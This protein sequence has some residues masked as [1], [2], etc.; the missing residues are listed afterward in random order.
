MSAQFD[1]SRF[2]VQVRGWYVQSGTRY[3]LS[4]SAIGQTS[5]S[6]GFDGQDAQTQYELTGTIT[7]GR[8]EIDVHERHISTMA[9]ATSL[10]LLPSQRGSASRF[11]AA[12]NS[13]VRVTGDEYRF[14]NVQ[15]QTDQRTRGT[16]T[17]QAGLTMLDG[18]VLQSG[19]PFGRLVLQAGQAFLQTGN[20]LIPLD[21]PR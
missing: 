7:G 16:T 20:N 21:M 5:G 8:M 19:R 13:V 3:E 14:Q 17:G 12:I 15:V 6:S 4:L 1:G 2:D 10:R 11:N 9:A 18:V